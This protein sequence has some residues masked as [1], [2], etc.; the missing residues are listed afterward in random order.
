MK[1]TVVSL[2]ICTCVFGA[3]ASAGPRQP[4]A[5]LAGFKCMALNVTD[6]QAMDPHFLVPLKQEPSTGSADVGRASSVVLVQDPEVARNGFL[7]AI[8]FNGRQGWVQ[9]SALKPWHSLNGSAERCIPSRM[10]DGSIGFDLK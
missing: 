3:T 8:L 1:G 10:S 7:A 4:V 6:Q 2:M 9:S 5:P